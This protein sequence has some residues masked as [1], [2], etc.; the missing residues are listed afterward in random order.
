MR[1]CA[2][3]QSSHARVIIAALTSSA[4]DWSKAIT[5][6]GYCPLIGSRSGH[7]THI[8]QPTFNEN[9]LNWNSNEYSTEY[10]KKWQM[11]HFFISICEET[12][13]SSKENLLICS[14]DNGWKQ[15]FNLIWARS[16]DMYM[17]VT[18]WAIYVVYLL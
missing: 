11:H 18:V 4:C 5:W 12:G 15:K 7:I 3:C 2:E 16:G 14:Q 13:K 1:G 9:G 17:G 8:I 10:S 6:A